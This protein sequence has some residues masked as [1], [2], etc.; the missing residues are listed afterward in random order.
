[1]SKRFWL[2]T[3]LTIFHFS[4]QAQT[5]ACGTME[6]LEHLK[7]ADP[8]VNKRM[9]DIEE[10]TNF[11]AKRLAFTREATE[12]LVVPV[13]VHVV[14][15]R[16]EENIPDEQVLS[17]IRVLNEDFQRKNPDAVS[18][19]PMF[20]HLA[21]DTRIEFRLAS[22][23]PDGQATNGITRT[24]TSRPEF[25]MGNNGVKFTSQGGADAWNPTEYLNIWVCNLGGGMLGYA[26]F[27]GGPIETDGVV[28]NYKN[29]GLAPGMAAPYDRGR[30]TT[31]E[32][33]H[34]LNLRH[35]WGDGPC[36]VD[37]FVDDTP[38]ADQATQGC[39]FA[40]DAC[41][42]PVMHQNFMDYT[43]DACMN[44]FTHG[45][46]NRMRALFQPG[47][48]RRSLLT[49]PALNPVEIRRPVV[50]SS[51]LTENSIVLAW[52]EWPGATGYLAE[53]RR[54]G[55]ARWEPRQMQRS[56][57]RITE[58]A[59]CTDYEFRITPVGGQ[60]G[61]TSEVFG[62]R[63]GGCTVPGNEQRAVGP[64]GLV[65]RATAPAEVS[66][67]WNPVLGASGYKLQVKESGSKQI[68]SLTTPDPVYVLRGVKPGV[69]YFYRVRAQFGSEAGPYSESASFELQQS[70]NA[71]FGTEV[72][73]FDA[74]RTAEGR[75]MVRINFQ[76]TQP[77][78]VSITDERG[79]VLWQDDQ[80]RPFPGEWYTLPFTNSVLPL[81][82]Q[83][84]DDQG[85]YF[86]K[87][88]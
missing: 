61:T 52:T 88:I 51:N 3:V 59:S 71:R 12:R 31:H 39:G 15:R 29:F 81:R 58:L 8:G 34:W 56:Y 85:F 19:E 60:P 70:A 21:S 32:V 27:P 13:V 38:M 48:F 46:A 62:F 79:K 35:I 42:G 64:A 9:A 84:A 72:P 26:Q 73:A 5:R 43:D 55:N 18:T 25:F 78:T 77:V 6:H 22:R 24:Y 50:E 68:I 49:S 36:G 63:T 4:S 30:T 10:A 86:E 75:I 74:S 53:F 45:Q 54:Q 33:G 41:G 82:I 69:K 11:T 47:G 67:S 65:S 76:D 1:M 80:F 87:K 37:D 16:A 23:T 2:A 20:A 57:V 14:Y 7:A 28:I 44:L 40:H 83:V 66:L 17:Q